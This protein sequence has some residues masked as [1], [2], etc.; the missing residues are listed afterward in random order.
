MY[1]LHSCVRLKRTLPGKEIPVGTMG[2]IVWVYGEPPKGYEV[3]FVDADSETI[4]VCTV[5][6]E[7]VESLAPP[8]T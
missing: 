1:E 2:A 8:R 6:E 7:D 3:E 4:D 5:S